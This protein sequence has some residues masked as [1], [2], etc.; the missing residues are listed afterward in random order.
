MLLSNQLARPKRS[1]IFKI[2]FS[3]VTKTVMAKLAPHLAETSKSLKCPHCGELLPD[4][5]RPSE[6]TSDTDNNDDVNE[7]DGEPPAEYDNRKLTSL[8]E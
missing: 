2:T 5:W 4:G 6:V 1:A 3:R 7:Q 8:R